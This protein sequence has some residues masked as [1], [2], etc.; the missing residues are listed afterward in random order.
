MKIEEIAV[1]Q[2]DIVVEELGI[3]IEKH[4]ES[5]DNEPEDLTANNRDKEP[6]ITIT[7]KDIKQL[8]KDCPL[9]QIVVSYADSSQGHIGIIYQATNWIFIGES[10]A[11]S[12]LINGKKMHK[13]TAHSKYGVNSVSKLK[14][15]GIHAEYVRDEVKFKYIYPLNAKER[16]K[17]LSLA[18]PYPKSIIKSI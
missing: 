13:K 14:Q 12:L 9:V 16:N 15:K 4:N 7:F 1:N 18:K 17:Y 3:D 2:H 10:Y 6:K 8:K 5:E 11:E